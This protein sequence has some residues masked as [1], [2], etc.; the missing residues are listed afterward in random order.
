ML[1][2]L[3]LGLSIILVFAG[4]AFAQQKVYTPE[5]GSAERT[6]ILNALRVP[7]EKELKQKIQFALENFNVQGNWAFL[8]GTSQNTDGGEPNF[9][10]TEYQKRIEFGA[11]DNNIFA[12]LK[13]TGGKWKVITYQ[14]GCT[15]VCYLGW[16][17]QYKAPKA[18]FP[19]T[20]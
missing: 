9:K 11:F 1:R 3:L 20:K 16:D 12:L 17:K 18:I 7:V 2:K 6:A 4:A 19:Y 13:K 10:N 8:G 14:I 5:K 15:D